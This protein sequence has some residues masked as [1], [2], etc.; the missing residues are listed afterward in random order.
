MMF[1]TQS[2]IKGETAPPPIHTPLDLTSRTLLPPIPSN[3]A[4]PVTAIPF[5][6]DRETPTLF[7]WQTQQYP[8]AKGSAIF[9]SHAFCPA[10][11]ESPGPFT[12]IIMKHRSTVLSLPSCMW[13]ILSGE[14]VTSSV[15]CWDSTGVLKAPGVRLLLEAAEEPPPEAAPRSHP[16]SFPEASSTR[17]HH[18]NLQRRKPP[19]SASP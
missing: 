8:P 3:P 6:A 2:A 10:L 9:R 7:T 11:S 4:V 15:P 13:L 12:S 16:S 1:Q 18:V 14:T 17:P 5:F 19:L